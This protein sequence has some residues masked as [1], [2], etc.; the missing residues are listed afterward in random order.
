VEFS[1]GVSFFSVKDSP[2][3][4]LVERKGF[5][6]LAGE[7]SSVVYLSDAGLPAGARWKQLGRQAWVEIPPR[8]EATTFRILIGRGDE[9]QNPETAL[10]SEPPLEDLVSLTKGG[11]ARWPETLETQGD[12]SASAEEAYVVDT[13]K[14]PEQNPWAA[15]MFIGGLDFF[16]DGR[17]ALSTFHGDVFIASGIDAKLEKIT[18]RRFAT[19]LYHALGLAVRDGEVYVTCR[20]GV[21]R[22]RDVDGNGEADFYEVFNGDLMVTKN[23]HEFVFDGQFDRDGCFYFAK[24]GPVRNGGRGFDEI[25]PHH[26]ALFRVT[27]DGRELHRVA[28]GFRAPN[29][30]GV[31][32]NAELTTGDNEG[33]WTPACKINW[34]QPGGF[35]GVVDL[36]HRESPP[37]KYDLPLCWL[38]KRVDNSGGGQVWVPVGEK[39]GPWSGQLLHLSY[40]QS[41]LLGVMRQPVELP[42]APD[43]CKH[44]VQGGVAQFPLKFQSG[45]MR[46]RFHP[47]DGQLYVAGLR[48]WQTT[49]IKNGCFQRVRYT[50]KPVRMPVGLEVK[51]DG[52][53]LTFTCS[54]DTKTASDPENWNVEVWNYIWSNAYGSP[55]VSTQGDAELPGE[56]G[57]DGAPQFGAAQLAKKHR[58]ALEVK[59]ATVGTDDRSVYLEIPGIKPVMQMSIRYGLQSADAVE[60]KGEVVNTIHALGD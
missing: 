15:P 48:G 8:A 43:C 5:A 25:V 1:E 2:A 17:A 28:T 55:E 60:L 54:L 19:G 39:W 49:G 57:R 44:V 50:G 30:I 29:G 26:G 58:D 41:S 23:F 33:T 46:A 11:P 22:L 56:Q 40:G 53:L 7:G 45:I 52:V 14:L 37:T 4:P 9:T 12:L 38:P 10:Q 42:G 6:R 13:I 35:Y 3:K 18:W 31:G 27:P 51:K 16:P 32:P 47:R 21:Y 24:A 36:A 59:S 20:D 34:V